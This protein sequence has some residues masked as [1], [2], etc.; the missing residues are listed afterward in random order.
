MRKSISIN[1]R[2]YATLLEKGGD[3]LVAFYAHLRAAKNGRD[4]YRPIIG[5]NGRIIKHYN[6]LKRET[7]FSIRT[8]KKYIQQLQELELCN[9]SNDGGFYLKGTNKI[10][11]E[12][13]SKKY[14]P[15]HLGETLAQTTVFSYGVRLH[16]MENSQRNHID[17]KDLRIN[18]LARA[19]KRQFLNPVEWKILKSLRKKGISLD[20][21][22]SNYCDKIILSRAGFGKLKDGQTDNPHKGHY[23]RNK[24]KSAGII[25][26]R[27]RSIMLQKCTK[28]QFLQYKSHLKNPRLNYFAGAMWEET[29]PEFC[30]VDFLPSEP[31]IKKPTTTYKK[32]SYLQ[33]DFLDFLING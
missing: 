21:L 3:R 19:E 31:K 7:S 10:N 8:L 18:I 22:Q 2:L 30:T 1:S 23:W 4:R 24:A 14:V 28:G 26:T 27:R 25:K 15:I 13:K 33:E 29:V 6:L 12:Y 5:G 32:L 9:F 20:S 16:A 17:R 11:K